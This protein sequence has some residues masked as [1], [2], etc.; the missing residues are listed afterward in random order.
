[1]NGEGLKDAR[2]MDKSQQTLY[3]MNRLLKI[4]GIEAYTARTNVGSRAEY[5]ALLTQFVE[6]APSL[7]GDLIRALKTRNAEQFQR[8]G[9]ELRKILLAIGADELLWEIKKT[10][11]FSRT[12]LWKECAERAVLVVSRV[13]RL[14]EQVTGARVKPGETVED[15]QDEDGDSGGGRTAADTPIVAVEQKAAPSGRPRAPIEP[16]RF[17][18]IRPLLKYPVQAMDY[19]RDLMRFSYNLYTDALLASLYSCL[20]KRD[21]ED[22]ESQFDSLMQSVREQQDTGVGERKK[23][24]VIDDAPD[25]L[26][27]VNT[28]LRDKYTVYCATNYMAALK[29]LANNSPDL[30]ILDIEMPGMNGFELIGIIRKL[31]PYATTPLFF[32]SANGTVE[33]VVASRKLG[34]NDFIKKPIDPSFL[35]SKIRQHL[36][37]EN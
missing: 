1:M 33:N 10:A 4:T 12:G 25:I 20:S 27:S 17:E 34:G 3:R 11:D 14:N 2:R 32:L 7:I 8:K 28:I 9:F 13:K 24:L 37:D 31:G 26:H 22:A 29:V 18:A 15:A 5:F 6:T 19:I 36:T 35:L 16:E 30:I 21:R 23:I